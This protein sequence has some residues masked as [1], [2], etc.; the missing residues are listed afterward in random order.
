[1][2]DACSNI[3][4]TYV[5]QSVGL[6]LKRT[7][8][9]NKSIPDS[10]KKK[11][12]SLPLTAI[13]YI[14][15]LGRVCIVVQLCLPTLHSTWSEDANLLLRSSNFAHVWP[16]LSALLQAFYLSGGYYILWDCIPIGQFCTASVQCQCR[17]QSVRYV[18]RKITVCVLSKNYN[19]FSIDSCVT[20]TMVYSSN[21]NLSLT[22]TKP[23]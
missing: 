4:C 9:E 22:I 8:D 14:F 11:L 23:A 13:D 20:L 10:K 12:F 21:H 6:F 17:M 1:M 19:Y 15:H 7:R 5:S 18:A 16:Y 2:I 3:S